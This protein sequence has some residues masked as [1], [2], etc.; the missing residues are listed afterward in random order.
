[1]DKTS[2]N[3]KYFINFKINVGTFFPSAIYVDDTVC[4]TKTKTIATEKLIKKKIFI[5]LKMLI[6]IRLNIFCF[7]KFLFG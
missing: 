1:M 2:N 6:F 5:Y 3:I 4:E 7:V